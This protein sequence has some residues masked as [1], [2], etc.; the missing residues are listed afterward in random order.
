MSL[1]SPL[2]FHHPQSVL[3]IQFILCL[4]S[5]D[6]SAEEDPSSWNPGKVSLI[7]LKMTRLGDIADDVRFGVRVL[8]RQHPPLICACPSDKLS[9]MVQPLHSLCY[10]KCKCGWSVSTD[11]RKAH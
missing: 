10:R 4:T 5:R 11:M 2:Y 7:A 8:Q 6:Y 9:L 3:R 1:T